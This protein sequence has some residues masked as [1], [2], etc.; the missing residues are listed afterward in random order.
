MDYNISYRKKDGAT[1][2]IISYKD[3]DGKWRQKS[4]QGFKRQKDA[5]PWIKNTVEKLEETIK[6][7][8]EFRGITFGDFKKIFLEDKKREFSYNNVSI[9]SYAF[10]KFKNL[11]PLLLTD[12]GYINLKPCVDSMIDKG[13]SNN[14]IELYT[15]KIKAVF[16]HAIDKYGILTS[17]P[18]RNKDYVLP[19]ESKKKKI[20]ALNQNELTGLLSGLD[21]EDYYISLIASKCGLRAGEIVGLTDTNFDFKNAEIK[22]DKQWKQLEKGVYSF[23]T[24]KSTNSYRTVPIPAKYVS[25]IK[26]YVKTC[27][28]GI[29][30]RIFVN[31]STANVTSRLEQKY[32]RK[33]YNISMH[34]L[35]HTYATTLLFNGFDYKTVAELMGD[36]VETIINTYSH[37]IDDMYNSAK[38]R[39]D[40]IL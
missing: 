7:P 38:N 16:N 11:E 33:G 14:T 18:V 26:S 31:R 28:I 24:P 25:E 6:T 9:Y 12:I 8:S 4:K 21:G 30:R 20:K 27:T 34:D 15:S 23:G 32:K 5:K 3:N 36:T 35:R 1:Q 39:I 29:D 13:L 17:N 19:K 37:F 22:I 40:N 2:C 10:A